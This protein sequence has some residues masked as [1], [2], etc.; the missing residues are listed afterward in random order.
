MVLAF[1][2]CARS[3]A[4]LLHGPHPF[5][6]F[7]QTVV[8]APGAA[9]RVA[10]HAV[11]AAALGVVLGFSASPIARAAEPA[12]TVQAAVSQQAV[13]A[14]SQMGR[15][16]SATDLS[17]TAKTIRVYLDQSGQPLHIFHTMKVV[18]RRPDRLAV[19]VTGDDGSND[20]F[21]DGRSA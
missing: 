10:R 4:H 14:V 20:L 5:R 3:L 16:L 7:V 13:T 9:S 12:P 17:F 1:T 15:T 19:Q 18:L 6:V 2:P 8:F 11:R 21:Y